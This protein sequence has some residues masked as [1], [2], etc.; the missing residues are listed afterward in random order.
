[1]RVVHAAEI[2]ALILAVSA[3]SAVAKGGTIGIYAVI[4]QV[5]F[6]PGT[7]QNAVRISG[8]FVV[9]LP[10]SSGAYGA[11]QRGYLYFR[12]P[13][14]MEDIVRKDWT[15]LAKIARTG[16]VV[17]FCQYWVPN[18]EDPPS[19]GHG[20]GNP[21]WALDVR[22]N[23]NGDAASPEPYPLPHPDGVVKAGDRANPD[24]ERVALQLQR[25]LGR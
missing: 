24:F 4:D 10:K 2:A 7:S 20:G 8:V 19:P 12:I 11:A 13:A 18:P 9:P 21:H 14:G 16:R 22:V 3:T 23:A 15:E 1:M 6:E 17:G 5:T 25:M